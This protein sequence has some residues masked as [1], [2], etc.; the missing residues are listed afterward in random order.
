MKFVDLTGQRFGRLTV[1][2]RVENKKSQAVWLCQ[3]D[4]GNTTQVIS[5]KLNNGHTKS[6]GC[7]AKDSAKYRRTTHGCR[8]TRLYGIWCAMKHRSSGTISD[9]RTKKWYTDRN[10]KRC[11]EW[12]NFE[13]FRDWAL[14]NGYAD[15]LSIDR[16]DVNGDYCLENCRWVNN[17][18]QGRNRTNNHLIT[19]KG[20]THCIEDWVD[21][22]G[23]PQTIIYSRA[24]RGWK[25]ED[26]FETKI[27]ERKKSYE[28]WKK[29]EYNGESH[30]LKKWSEIKG[31]NYLTLKDRLKNGWGIGKALETP[32]RGKNK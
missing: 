8:K 21:I 2:K 22:T 15:N 20:E 27:G 1:I 25:V 29:H 3:C 6:C 17:K 7:Y 5:A 18:T 23:I 26:I 24:R 19:Y 28:Y 13:S 11:K 12:D 16:I 31:I 4:C 32:V 14:N 9:Q 10:I 30:S